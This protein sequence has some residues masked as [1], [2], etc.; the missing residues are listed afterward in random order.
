MSLR[1]TSKNFSNSIWSLIDILLYPIVF[2]LSVPYFIKHLNTE[3]FGIWMLLNTI[4]IGLQMFN[5]GMGAGM[6]KHIAASIH[7][8]DSTEIN[9]IWNQGLSMSI[10]QSVLIL[11]IT[12]VMA[13]LIFQIDLFAI[14]PALKGLVAQSIIL[15]G[16][17]VGLRFF[18]QISTN[19]F[20]AH[21]QYQAAAYIT[22]SNR[23]VP[24]LINI[25]IIQYYPSIIVLVL[26][27]IVCNI[28]TALIC[29]FIITK[30]IPNFKFK[31]E[32][33]FKTDTSKFA[34]NLWLQSLCM[35]IIFQTDRY[36]MVQYFGLQTLTFYA[37]VA[38]MFNH[39]HMGFNA[40]LA[41]VMPKFVKQHAHHEDSKPLFLAAR[42]VILLLSTNGV[43][44][45][46]FIFP[47]ILPLILG[48]SYSEK[49]MHF[50][51]PFLL[52][53]IYLNATTIPIFYLNASGNEGIH[54]KFL[55]TFTVIT[56]L[57]LVI[58]PLV[59]ASPITIPYVLAGAFFMVMIFYNFFSAKQL[60]LKLNNLK[61]I[62]QWFILPLMASIFILFPNNGWGLTALIGVSVY[63]IY[64]LLVYRKI[65][66]TTLKKS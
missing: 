12:G 4:I 54:L 26:S 1:L 60:G 64:I 32:R 48:S 45:L 15:T 18:E 8:H 36:L 58:S 40:I 46:H 29:Y 25:L 50:T 33:N 37:L 53:A 2:F 56:L 39:M 31:F 22:T 3:I 20:K 6:L 42:N 52:L 13:L 9:K 23:L 24:L 66:W 63:T 62:G 5:F 55:F 43:I 27:N 47:F 59:V 57:S 19:Y 51:Q 44:I 65:Y 16:V 41:W 21:E 61:D 7:K 28:I 17:W 49:I 38:T 35:I 30:Q 10:I 14:T 34:F 11:I